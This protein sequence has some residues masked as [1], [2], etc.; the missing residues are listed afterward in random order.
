[1]VD[2]VPRSW[3]H[4]LAVVGGRPLDPHTATPESWR[5]TV[6]ERLGCG[7]PTSLGD[8]R[9][10]SYRPWEEGYDPDSWLDREV[11]AT[12]RAAFPQHGLDPEL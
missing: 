11:L 6:R 8:G 7:S 10:P 9:A 5:A 12:R 1:M 4:L 2:V 3:T